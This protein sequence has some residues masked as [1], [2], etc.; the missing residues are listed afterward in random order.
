MK[1]LLTLHEAIVIALIKQPNR[2]ATFEEIAELIHKRNLF[3]IR[4]GGVPLAKQIMLRSTK[5]KG[6]YLH[7][8]EQTNESTIRL[9]NLQK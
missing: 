1:N 2:T 7:L 8:F 3:P 5:S 4:K 9:R 6:A